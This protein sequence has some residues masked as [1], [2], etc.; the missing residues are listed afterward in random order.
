[1]RGRREK[2]AWKN[3]AWKNEVGGITPHF[4]K[5]IVKT[6]Y[7]YYNG[8][9]LAMADGGAKGPSPFNTHLYLMEVDVC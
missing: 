2:D 8:K 7:M 3:D 1:M 4:K 6:V 5:Q 9:R